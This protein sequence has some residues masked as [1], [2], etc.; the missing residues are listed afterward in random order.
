M[1]K[2]LVT[3]LL[4]IHAENIIR[5]AD[6]HKIRIENKLAYGAY[7]EHLQTTLKLTW[8]C[9]ADNASTLLLKPLVFKKTC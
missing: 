7:T 3:H 4:N 9:T 8:C 1:L 2:R 6:G 5:N